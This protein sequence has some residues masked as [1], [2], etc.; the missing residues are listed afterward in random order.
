MTSEE[1]VDTLGKHGRRSKPSKYD[2]EGRYAFVFPNTAVPLTPEEEHGLV[3]IVCSLA[4]KVRRETE[5]WQIEYEMN[6]PEGVVHV[7][8]PL[9]IKRGY[10][11]KFIKW[12]KEN[13]IPN[14]E[15]T[16]IYKVRSNKIELLHLGLE[17]VR[18]LPLKQRDDLANGELLAS[19]EN[20]VILIAPNGTKYIYEA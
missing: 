10:H 7:E 15:K 6:T 5:T 16:P 8:E 19:S 11:Q 2:K 4:K 18:N 17:G 3:D 20:P 9:R 14:K 1:T 13:I 12:A